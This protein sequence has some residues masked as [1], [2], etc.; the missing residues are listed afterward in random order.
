M[1][2]LNII[3]ESI[4]Q[5]KTLFSF[6][7]IILLAS[8]FIVFS[9]LI[10]ARVCDRRISKIYRII[11]K[12]EHSE[13][14]LCKNT[15][16]II[17]QLKKDKELKCIAIHFR[18]SLLRYFKNGSGYY[19][20]KNQG[21]DFFNDES[22]GYELFYGY[23]ISPTILTGIGV[24]GTFVGLTMAMPEIGELSNI[25]GIHDGLKIFFSAARIAFTTSIVGIV[26]NIICS[27]Y[28]RHIRRKYHIKIADFANNIIDGIY[29]PNLNSESDL[30]TIGGVIENNSVQSCVDR[31]YR[32]VVD[33]IRQT[34]SETA[35]VIAEKVS[36][37]I[38]DIDDRTSEVIK[39]TLDKLQVELNR[40]LQS[41]IENIK[42]ASE[43]YI[44]STREAT[45]IIANKYEE[46]GNGLSGVHQSIISDVERWSS[47]AKCVSDKGLEISNQINSLI[48][49]S[50]ENN[51]RISETVSS[52]NESFSIVKS[53]INDINA[54]TNDFIESVRE[55]K[56]ASE[57]IGKGIES[58]KNFKPE[59][60]ESIGKVLDINKKYAEGWAAE[61][62]KTITHAINNL[63]LAIDKIGSVVKD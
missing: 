50:D 55:L 4:W 54:Y 48:Q 49:K 25:S 20:N 58:I 1:D 5:D 22:L 60:A 16:D 63:C 15:E 30:I 7:V 33:A 43:Q 23:A 45:S 3:F 47:V 52:L 56:D 28:V 51:A 46:I 21:S 18:N 34:S 19:C 12:Y 53:S 36:L 38:K 24:L 39:A 2:N 59:I 44:D 10:S 8:S 37:Y 32:D 29:P 26:T 57:Q 42:L 13:C 62:N 6:C 41:Q 11:N 35:T 31:M 17:S 40:S 9:C 14:S 61:Y 27:I